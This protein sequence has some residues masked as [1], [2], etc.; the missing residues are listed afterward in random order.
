M[1]MKRIL[2]KRKMKQKRQPKVLSKV[3]ECFFGQ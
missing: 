3:E 1:M 2:K